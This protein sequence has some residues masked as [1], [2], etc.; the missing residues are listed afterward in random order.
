MPYIL[1]SQLDSLEYFCSQSSYTLS[2]NTSKKNPFTVKAGKTSIKLSTHKDF[3]KHYLLNDDAWDM[4][5]E[6]DEYL[7]SKGVDKGN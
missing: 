4:L 3:P 2:S 7:C 5:E 6:F 1:K